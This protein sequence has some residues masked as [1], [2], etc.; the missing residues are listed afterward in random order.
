MKFTT[1]KYE[2]LQLE[3]VAKSPLS[4]L[5]KQNKGKKEGKNAPTKA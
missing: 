2:L 1:K 5:L 4:I 3:R